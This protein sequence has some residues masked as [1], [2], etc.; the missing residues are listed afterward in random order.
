MV[1]PFPRPSSVQPLPPHATRVFQGVIFDV[2]Q[3]EQKDFDG[4]TRIFEKLKRADTVIILPVTLE[5][6]ILYAWEEQPRRA[7]YFSTIGGRVDNGEDILD[8]A[9]REL[10]EETGYTSTDW[11]SLDAAHP[12]T[13]MDWCIFTLVARGC[14]RIAEQDL[15]GGERMDVRQASFEEFIQLIIREDFHE[16]RLKIRFLEALSDAKKMEVLR[17]QIMG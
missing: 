3:W 17:A 6:K 16:E 7:P 2:Y 10:L 15:D 5:G 13:K 11:I 8:A 14:E 1:T 4:N 12:T 9:K